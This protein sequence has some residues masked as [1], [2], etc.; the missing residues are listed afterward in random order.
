MKED[1]S[2]KQICQVPTWLDVVHFRFG[3]SAGLFVA[4][5]W[6]KKTGI[7]IDECV[8]EF[9]KILF[10]RGFNRWCFFKKKRKRK[11][12]GSNGT[13]P[14]V[15][16][17]RFRR[18]LQQESGRCWSRLGAGEGVEGIFQ[19][20]WWSGW[21]VKKK[22]KRRQWSNDSKIGYWLCFADSPPSP[23]APRV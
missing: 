12:N 8:P 4:E 13:F 10:P 19:T 1:D 23:L 17:L 21:R 20:A 11:E 9:H 5:K 15:Q 22:K 14:V 7:Y 16:W 18:P 6:A 2:Y 3:Y